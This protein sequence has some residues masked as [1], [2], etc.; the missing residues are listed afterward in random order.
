MGICFLIVLEDISLRLR[1]I[2]LFSSEGCE[3]RLFSRSLIVLTLF[4][5]CVCLCLVSSSCKD[6][7]QI[8]LG[9]II[10]TSSYLIKE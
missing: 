10:M 2:E 8:K 1:S 6:T 5:L 3:G 7:S 4:S 9:S